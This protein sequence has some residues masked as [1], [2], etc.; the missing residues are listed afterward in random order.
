MKD[1]LLTV[2]DKLKSNNIIA[3]FCENR[4]KLYEYPETAD[5]TKPFI[6][7]DPLDVPVP[8]VYAS[9]KNHAFEYSYQIDVQGQSY[10][11]VKIIAEAIRKEMRNMGFEQFPGGLDEYFKETKRYVD[12]RRYHATIK[13][14]EVKD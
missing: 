9:D 5:D 12:A 4:I 14:E 13:N 7:I 3:S 1:M 10:E 11:S 6:V 8:T 2:H